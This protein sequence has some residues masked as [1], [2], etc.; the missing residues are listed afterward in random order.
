MK[1][2]HFLMKDI[3]EAEAMTHYMETLGI[4]HEH[5]H[6]TYKH[7][8][9]LEERHLHG[10]SFWEEVDIIHSGERGLMIGFIASAL[11]SFSLYNLL[12]GQEIALI[13][14]MF[15]GLVT[16]GFCTWVGGMIGASCDNYRLDPYHDQLAAGQCLVMV[17]VPPHQERSFL[18]KLNQ[19]FPDRHVCGESSSIDNP[20]EGSMHLH[21]HTL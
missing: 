13:V 14:T 17:D 19:Q 21:K 2:L 16:L 4:A 11:V 18:E 12:Y 5:T 3:D 8:Q 7:P 9:A 10:T 1:Q 6:V 15:A 20:F